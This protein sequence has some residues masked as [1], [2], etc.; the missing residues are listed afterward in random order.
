M[1]G[2][3]QKRYGYIKKTLC[4]TEGFSHYGLVKN[5]LREVSNHSHSIIY[6]NHNHLIL[7]LVVGIGKIRY[8]LY[9]VIRKTAQF[10]HASLAAIN[11]LRNQSFW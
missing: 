10:L 7:K 8:R 11:S 9:T 5:R 1:A 6:N 2:S 4:K 3:R